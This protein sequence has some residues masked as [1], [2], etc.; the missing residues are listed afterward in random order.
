[1]RAGRRPGSSPRACRSASRPAGTVWSYWRTVRPSCEPG[2]DM[3]WS[4]SARYDWTAVGCWPKHPSRRR[5]L[6]SNPQPLTEW[7]VAV[8]REHGGDSALPTWHP[9][10]AGISMLASG[11]PFLPVERL[12]WN[13]LHLCFSTGE[14]KVTI[15]YVDGVKVRGPAP[16]AKRL[17]TRERGGAGQPL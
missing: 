5:V 13:I 17:A 8:I 6:W 3:G 9:L 4:R 14:G 10:S 15:I 12:Q 7:C 2:R 1:M 16:C 11:A